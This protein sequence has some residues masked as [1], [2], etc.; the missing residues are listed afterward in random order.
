MSNFLTP[1]KQLLFALAGNKAFSRAQVRELEDKARL[2]VAL[3][4][5]A[6]VIF[7]YADFIECLKG[8]EGR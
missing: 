3:P 7:R 8:T 2:P 4:A 1:E 6:L 5:G